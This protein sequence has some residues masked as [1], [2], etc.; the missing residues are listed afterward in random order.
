MRVIGRRPLGAHARGLL[1][2]LEMQ[3]RI[4]P[5]SVPDRL[6]ITALE[7]L[8]DLGSTTNNPAH[9]VEAL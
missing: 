1:L 5:K 6:A 3:R 8:L 7:R 2:G 4:D 9:A